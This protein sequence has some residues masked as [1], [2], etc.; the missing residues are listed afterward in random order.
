MGQAASIVNDARDAANAK[1]TE[2][3]KQTEAELNNLSILL[4]A[5]SQQFM[6][7]LIANK[8]EDKTVPIK[9]VLCSWSL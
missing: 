1:A 3:E 5:R 6:S 7:K 2:A 9:V 4:E 8:G